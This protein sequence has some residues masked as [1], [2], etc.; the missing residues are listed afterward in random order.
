MKKSLIALFIVAVLLLFDACSEEATPDEPSNLSP[1]PSKA[2]DLPSPTL[3]G[4]SDDLSPVPTEPTVKPD[5]DSSSAS[6]NNVGTSEPFSDEASIKETVLVDEKDVKITA[7]EL[8]YGKYSPELKIT[9]EN[10]SDKNLSFSSA[11]LSYNCNSIN[12]YMV[13]T[14]YLNTD[15][16]AGKKAKAS[17]RFD[18]DEMAL[19]G[20]REIA[21]I[22]IGFKVTDD[23]YDTYLQTGPLQIKTS[24]A[25]TYDYSVDTYQWAISNN[26][27]SESYYSVSYYEIGEFYSKNG[28]KLLS[29]AVLKDSDGKTFLLLEFENHTLG[30]IYVSLS[31]I[32]ANG[33]VVHDSA[34]TG[35]LINVGCRCIMAVPI[36]SMIDEPY[37]DVFGIIEI[38]NIAFSVE[39]ED[40]ERDRIIDQEEFYILISSEAAS[41]DNS[42]TELYNKNGIRIIYKGLVPD[43]FEYSDDVHVLL[44]VESNY[45]EEINVSVNYD[46]VSVNGFMTRFICYNEN[47]AVG[48][49]AILDVELQGSSLKESDVY[50]ISDIA[51]V[52]MAIEI[53]NKKYH[54]IEE[55]VLTIGE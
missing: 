17:I 29:E 21:D 2:T 55:P 38:G 8:V 9:I 48:K 33:L 54:T 46:S 41:F 44:L 14:G 37:W 43:A 5:K 28:I 10:N 6:G 1:V 23:N 45:S 13:D 18:S 16:A 27:F 30:S 36:S 52:E 11:T 20:I 15:V 39:I 24:I 12:G 53:R 7:T 34:W 51:D 22:G 25:D 32:I 40:S 3:A 4:S 47:I 31:N 19:L 50:S 26:L 42:G 49:N 35:E